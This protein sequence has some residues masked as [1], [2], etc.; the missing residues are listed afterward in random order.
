MRRR[1][2][3]EGGRTH[4]AGPEAGGTGGSAPGKGPERHAKHRGV[5][6]G[7]TSAGSPGLGRAGGAS[8]GAQA[9]PGEAE[10]ILIGARR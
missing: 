1:E 9:L 5:C 6:S 4:L 3:R 7:H 2:V 8:G 10:Q